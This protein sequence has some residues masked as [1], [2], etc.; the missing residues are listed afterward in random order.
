MAASVSDLRA[1]SLTAEFEGYSDAQLEPFLADAAR[2]LDVTVWG[3]RYDRAQALLAAHLVIDLAAAG[4]GGVAPAVVSESLGPGSRTYDKPSSS[5][6]HG[7]LRLHATPYGRLF[8]ALF[9]TLPLSPM[10]VFDGT[11]VPDRW[12]Y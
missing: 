12:D 11:I 7:Q 10:V 2:F 1:V 8:A 6:I 5:S 4:S 9:D 3:D